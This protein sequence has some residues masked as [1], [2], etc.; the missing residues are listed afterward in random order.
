[1]DGEVF[2][3]FLDTGSGRNFISK[4]AA[5]KLQVSPARHES[6]EIITI[7]GTKRQSMPIYNLTIESLDGT[8]KEDIALAGSMMQDFTTVK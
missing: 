1:M 2:W 3:A 5:K 6:K 4:D 7:N 8:A